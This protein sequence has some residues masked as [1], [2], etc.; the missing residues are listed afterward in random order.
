M[1]YGRHNVGAYLSCGEEEKEDRRT[2]LICSPTANAPSPS[3]VA[4]SARAH[5]PSSASGRDDVS[6][7]IYSKVFTQISMNSIIC[8]DSM[9]FHKPRRKPQ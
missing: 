1:F 3:L 2:A 9:L 4:D 7:R 6:M 5:F 8:Y